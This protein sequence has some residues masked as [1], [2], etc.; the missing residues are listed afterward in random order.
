MKLKIKLL[1]VLSLFL[2]SH[3]YAQLSADSW[4]LGLGGTYPRFMGI[5]SKAYSGT[6]NYGAYIS[7]KRNFS[8]NVALRFLVNYNYMEAIYD[9]TT[10]QNTESVT[11]GTG[12]LD[13][14]YYLSPCDPVSPFI[15]A[16]FGGIYFRPKNTFEKNL[17]ND[18]LEYQFNLRGGAEWHIADNW[19]FVTEAS[20]ITPSSNKLDGENNT[21]EHKGLLGT[22]CDTYMTLNVGFLYYFSQG[23]PSQKCNLPGGV[24]VSAPQTNQLTASDVE[25][26]VKQYIPKEV[27][28]EVVVEK[29]SAAPDKNWILV[30]VNFDFNSANLTRESFPI[31][32]NALQILVDNPSMK[33]E[34]RGYTDNIGSDGYNLSLSKRRSQV[35]K[36][37]MTA[38]G[39]SSERLEVKGMGEADPIGD[40]N[41]SEGRILNRRIEFKVKK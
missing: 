27:V 30:G 13:L 29:P 14:L 36:D 34:I 9:F 8:E 37:Y 24:T 19:K 12:S 11:M 7:L 21:H 39:I 3:S 2:I 41:T 23:N 40:N 20:Y 5:W 35:V 25:R 32:L 17:S 1:C 28:K 22:N 38:N 6:E 10:A 26:I 18:F 31:L 16:G 33:I 15:A 4:S